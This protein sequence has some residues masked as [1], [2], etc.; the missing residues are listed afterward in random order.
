MLEGGGIHIKDWEEVLS[1]QE[2]GMSVSCL[3][4]CV[5]IYAFTHIY[6]LLLRKFSLLLWGAS[7]Y[8]DII[9]TCICI[10]ISISIR[11]CPYF[12]THNISIYLYLLCINTRV[13]CMYMHTCECACTCT[14]THTCT[15][16]YLCVC[17][18]LFIITH[19]RT[20]VN[21]VCTSVYVFTHRLV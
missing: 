4:V 7:P 8:A 11:L 13:C 19:I 17:V 3:F 18:Q 10:C 2:G 16:T 21:C 5:Y 15:H 1:S 20:C 12:K 14:H 6:A 9:S